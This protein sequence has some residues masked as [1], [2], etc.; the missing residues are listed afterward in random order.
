MI[1]VQ[2]QREI[3]FPFVFDVELVNILRLN[4]IAVY[5]LAKMQ[6]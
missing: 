6:Q 1:T 4:N 2:M 5:M 3:C